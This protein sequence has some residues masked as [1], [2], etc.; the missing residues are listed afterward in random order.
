MQRAVAGSSSTA[1]KTDVALELLRA[2]NRIL[3]LMARGAPLAE[4]LDA[5]ALAAEGFLGENS[6]CAILLLD[7]PSGRLLH[8]AAPSLPASYNEAIHGVQIGPEVGTCG[9]A[10]CL[11]EIVIT[12]DIST[13]PRWSQLKHLPLQNGLRSAWSTPIVS[14]QG[15]VLGTFGVYH[16]DLS[17]PSDYALDLVQLFARTAAIAIERKHAE[18]D[19]AL[20]QQQIETL[21][22]TGLTL[23]SERELQTVVQAATD[24]GRELCGAEFGAFFY[25]VVDQKGESYMLYTLSG[26]ER[27]KFSKFPM[28]RNTEVFAPTFRG[29]GVVRSGNIR[30]DPRYGKNAPRKGIPEGHLPVVSY[31]AVPVLSRTGAVLGGL[32]FGHS[33]PDIFTATSER[34]ITSVAAQAAVA[35]DN[36]HLHD[37]LTKQLK[38]AEEVQQRLSIAQRTARLATWEWN[39]ETAEVRFTPGSAEIYGSPLEQMRTLE[40]WLK[41]VHPDDR[42]EVAKRVDAARSR[43][44]E[45]GAEYRVFR[46]GTVHWVLS[47]GHVTREPETGQPLTIVGLSMDITERKKSEE[48]LRQSEKLAAT[49]RLAATI[50]HEINNPL[51]AVTN[52]IYLAKSSPDLSAEVR[53]QL[54]IADQELG[55][56]THIAQQTLGFY[57][58][59][60]GPVVVNVS[61]TITNVLALFYRKMIY[62]NIGAVTEL[63]PEVKVRALQGELRQVLSNLV[64][65]AIDASNSGS[66][67]FIRSRLLKRPRGADVVQITVA[68]QGHGISTASRDHIFAPFFTTKTEVGTGL[69]LWVTKGMVEK[70]GGKIRFR[71]REGTRS[72]TVFRVLLPANGSGLVRPAETE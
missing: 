48:A 4:I 16:H 58:D 6:K 13:D 57:R 71:S 67:L 17:S 2:E 40:D 5:L 10:A 46:E 50:A 7:Q 24:A 66:Q 37:N 47:R 18:R 33:Q 53:H 55:R 54:D 8:G 1:S 29:D 32:F 43:G 3:E 56:V 25:N 21:Y 35:L 69:G 14:S 23:S 28:P 41:Q 20:F 44:E 26:V 42:E 38:R 52:F 31:L 64:S 9:R 68:D 49:G 11:N 30:K 19:A 63:A 12:P 51:E 36:A 65:N 60:S 15:D 72:G 27:E 61:E 39:L 59:T 70:H 34:L 22:R 62:K 45:Y